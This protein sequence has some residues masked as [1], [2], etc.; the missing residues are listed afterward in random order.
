MNNA[1]TTASETVV[2]AVEIRAAGEKAGKEM[3]KKKMEALPQKVKTR[4]TAEAML[5]AGEGD[6]EQLKKVIIESWS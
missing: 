1:T 4:W 5:A 2:R 3:V 6:S